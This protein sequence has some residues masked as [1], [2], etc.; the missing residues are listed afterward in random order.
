MNKEI[1]LQYL[2]ELESSHELLT[3]Y[4]EENATDEEYNDFYTDVEDLT[5]GISN[6]SFWINKLK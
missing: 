6:L 5:T 4:V 1:L 3:Q 2:H